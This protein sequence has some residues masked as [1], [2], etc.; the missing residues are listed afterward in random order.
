MKFFRL[1][2]EILF[3]SSFPNQVLLK[4]PSNSLLVPQNIV[5]YDLSVCFNKGLDCSQTCCLSIKCAD[6]LSECE[7]FSSRA[8]VE[9]YIGIISLIVLIF[10]VPFCIRASHCC[11]SYRCC[12]R[13]QLDDDDEDLEVSANE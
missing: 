13:P 10:V 4:V 11:L 5:K 8:F 3:L 6:E 7:D 9:L 12:Q 1:S 2:Y